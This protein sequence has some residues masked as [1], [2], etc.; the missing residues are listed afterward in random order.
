MKKQKVLSSET[1]YHL[2]PSNQETITLL[3]IAATNH[4]LPRLKALAQIINERYR[5]SQ[6]RDTANLE[7]GL[8]MG[9]SF[10]EAKALKKGQKGEFGKWCR[11]NCSVNDTQRRIYQRLDRN[12][13]LIADQ[14]NT[15]VVSSIKGALRLISQ[16]SQK[17]KGSKKPTNKL[18]GR[19]TLPFSDIEVSKDK[20]KPY[21]CLIFRTTKRQDVADTYK[22]ITGSDLPPDPPAEGPAEEFES[23]EEPTK[24]AEPTV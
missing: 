23:V 20:K 3:A 16:I 9:S 8:I 13:D 17:S 4:D 14:I 19:V 24:L 5:A 1:Q 2:L 12:R 18:I 7:D 6:D 22:A 11:I 15:G 10:N 21:Y